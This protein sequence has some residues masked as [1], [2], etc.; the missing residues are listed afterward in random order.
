MRLARAF[1]AGAFAVL[2]MLATRG[3]A[4]PTSTST[5]TSTTA[6]TSTSTS[7]STVRVGIIDL[8]QGGSFRDLLEL[9]T[10]LTA[11]GVK[12]E[13]SADWDGLLTGASA[14]EQSAWTAILEAEAAYAARACERALPLTD[15]AL[16]QL[17][18][19]REAEA[20]PARSA[21]WSLALTCADQLGDAV[22]ARIAARGLA[23]LGDPPAT[24]PPAVWQRWAPVD[25]DAVVGVP[26]V[27]RGRLRIES[28]V[29]GTFVIVDGRDAGEAPVEVDLGP[30]AHTL[31]GLAPGH[32]PGES[33][34][35]FGPR[36][37][38]QQI[39][40]LKPRP[41]AEAA[42]RDAILAERARV[43]AA[44]FDIAAAVA[45]ARRVRWSRALVLD[46]EGIRLVEV[47]EGIAGPARGLDAAGLSAISADVGRAGSPAAAAVPTP[48]PTPPPVKKKK[49]SGPWPWI[50]ASTVAAVALTIILIQP[51][52]GDDSLRIHVQVP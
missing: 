44:R 51:D 46:A 27:P 16:A 7:T 34:L 30:G 48:S 21:A 28:S 41:S 50:A 37:P 23:G 31:F 49:R 38:S 22:R 20:T 24:V 9:T 6:S 39:Q 42:A 8:R 29:P 36:P 18:A 10:R 13:T 5:S 15:G 17:L 2:G 32:D 47:P 45:L 4:A 52:G 33:Q 40:L 1:A 11:L 3:R 26:P 43:A 14:P 12:L 19:V 25:F 35:D